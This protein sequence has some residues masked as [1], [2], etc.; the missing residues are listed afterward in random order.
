MT[1]CAAFAH[2]SSWYGDKV[3]ILLLFFWFVIPTLS[4]AEGER[5]CFLPLF[6]RVHTNAI[7][8]HKLS[9]ST[10][11]PPLRS[12]Q[13]KNGRKQVRSLRSE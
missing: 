6:V 1:F 3:K 13:A 2:D 11:P 4:E 7:C 8:S 10:F 5:T 12:K 9:F